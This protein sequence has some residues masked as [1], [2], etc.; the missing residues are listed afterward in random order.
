[1]PHD[2]PCSSLWRYV[3]PV[4]RRVVCAIFCAPSK[5]VAQRFRTA[6]EEERTA[7][8]RVLRGLQSVFSKSTGKL[9]SEL[10]PEN[11]ISRDNF[12]EVLG[13]M[14]RAELLTVTDAV[15]E[16][17]GKQIPTALSAL[18]QPGEPPIRPRQCTS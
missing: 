8:Y 13:A 17:E 14:A 1:M 16:K 6:T 2:V 5:C 7:L 12:E 4:L 3:G 10:F 9:Y 15:F 11:E 18:L